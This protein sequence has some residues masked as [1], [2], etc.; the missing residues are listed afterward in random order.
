MHVLVLNEYFPPD[1][2]ATAKN[3]ALVV[4]ALAER[5]RVTVLAGRPSYDPTERHPP[6]LLR[7]EVCGN[8]TVERVGSTAFPRFRMK[9]RVSNYLTYLALAIPRA[10]AIHP[11][12]I[13][14]M[15]DPPIE[16]IA[17][18]LV[19]RLSGRP[20]VYNLRDMYPDMAVGGEIVRPASWVHRWEELH[21]RALRR[22]ARVIVLGEDMRERILA[23]GVD[24]ARISVVRDAVPFTE[25][26][27][28]FD[29][30]VVNEI[31]GSFRFVL[32]HAGNLGFYGAWQT[33]IK[34]ARMLEPEGVGLVF[35][36]EGARKPQIED[37]A[38]G[39]SNVRFLPFRPASELPYVMAAGD[40]HVVTVK[41]GLE[42]VVVPSKVYNILAA[43]RP[44]LAVATQETEVARFAERDGCGLA[45]DPDDPG[46]VA[47]AVRSVLPN[48]NRLANMSQRA[49]ELAKTYDR[50]GQLRLFVEAIESAVCR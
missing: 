37:A 23:K 10:L 50:V 2:S 16:G 22:A 13:V 3:A 43:G 17:G 33:L 35:I 36:G 44:L 48:R 25:T 20:F 46:A 4:G 29:H 21:R 42:G 14:A 5:H 30:P 28:P 11:D 31:R 27:P 1:T 9:R 15:T 19:S 45:A 40:L 34:A 38:R 32:V 47:A 24:P 26:L 18:A 7:R 6:Y 12:V 8:L 49:R 41:R 39:C